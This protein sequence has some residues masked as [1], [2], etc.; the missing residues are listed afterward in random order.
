MMDRV[1]KS[2]GLQKVGGCSVVFARFEAD[3]R[4]MEFEVVVA[5]EDLAI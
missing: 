1:G 5:C 3:I 2:D 4:S